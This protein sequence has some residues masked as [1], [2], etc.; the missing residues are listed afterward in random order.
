MGMGESIS[1]N[2]PLEGHVTVRVV[3]TSS[4]DVRIEVTTPLQQIER[5]L[6]TGDSL[7]VPTIYELRRT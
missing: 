7:L 6:R 3:A 5:T 1:L 2:E 4:D